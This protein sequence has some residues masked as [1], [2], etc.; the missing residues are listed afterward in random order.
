LKS[1][2]EGLSV[3]LR[4]SDKRGPVSH[5]K[6]WYYSEFA[7]SSAPFTMGP[8]KP[9]MQEL[10]ASPGDWETHRETITRLYL[11]ERRSLQE[12]MDCMALNHAF[13]AT[14]DP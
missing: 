11:H 8:S 6:F 3:F 2:T 14:C 9:S 1:A 13:F 5:F 12:V 7:D 4:T 10:F